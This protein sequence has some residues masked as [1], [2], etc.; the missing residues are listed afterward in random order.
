MA[1]TAHPSPQLKG[2]WI[3][4]DVFPKLTSVIDRQTDHA[5]SPHLRTHHIRNTAIRYDGV[6]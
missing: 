1:P 4:S 6:Y 2:I 5:T 3:G